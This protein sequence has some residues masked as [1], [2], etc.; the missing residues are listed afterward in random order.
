M[1][2]YCNNQLFV[3][4]HGQINSQV[5]PNIP[6][7]SSEHSALESCGKEEKNH[8]DVSLISQLFV[9][10]ILICYVSV[11]SRETKVE[12]WTCLIQN[13]RIHT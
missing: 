8:H 9:L 10:E 2:I 13:C 11:G 4:A 12:V 5:N 3:K 7:H 1:K 6:E